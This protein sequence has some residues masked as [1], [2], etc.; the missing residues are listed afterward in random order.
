M[1]VV[2]SPDDDVILNVTGR[3]VIG[4]KTL[5]AVRKDSAAGEF[6]F[7]TAGKVETDLLRVE[8]TNFYGS[9]VVIKNNAAI[10][11][12]LV[13]RSG[14]IFEAG[15]R[16][17]L[18]GSYDG[19]TYFVVEKGRVGI[20][21]DSPQGALDVNGPIYQRGTLLHADYVFEDDYQLESIEEHAQFIR[22]KKH[23]KAIPKAKVDK[24]G[25]EIIEVGD[26][27]RGIVKELEKA[28]IYIEQLHKH[29]KVLEERFAELEA[30]VNAEK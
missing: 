16:Q 22:M 23:L 19:A 20:N 5:F 14:N 2:G 27:Q 21:T 1:H 29:I 11:D 26:H 25:L 9:L 8:E 7:H 12:G 28:H 30:R 13:I 17:L 4:S 15:S 18:V 3:E 24:N 10:G 6:G